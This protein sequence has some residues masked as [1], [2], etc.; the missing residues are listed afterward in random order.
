MPAQFLGELS[1]PN[2]SILLTLLERA[3]LQ[4]QLT[5]LTGNSLKLANYFNAFGITALGAPFNTLANLPEN[6]QA[7]ALLTLSPSRA[8]FPR[9][10][11]IQG[12]LS[13]SRL[14]AQRLGNERILRETSMHTSASPCGPLDRSRQSSS[15]QRRWRR[16]P[17][18]LWRRYPT[19][20]QEAV[21]HLD[22]RL[23]GPAP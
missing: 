10:D 20:R 15:L 1:Y 17:N 7:A 14:V 13:F 6:D 21:Q 12:A 3:Q 22:Q 18:P 16:P 9:Y 8:A 5:G 23:W 4:L 19:R 11:N 2:N